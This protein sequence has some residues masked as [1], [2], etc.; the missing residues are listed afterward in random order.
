MFIQVKLLNGFKKPLW[1]KVPA[2][3]TQQSLKETIIQVPLRNTIIPAVVLREQL[4]HPPVAFEIKEAKEIEPFPADYHYMPFVTQLSSYYVINPL[5]IIMRIKSF[6]THE[7]KHR[8]PKIKADTEHTVKKQVTL[9]SEQQNIVDYVNPRIENPVYAP[10]VIHGVTG[11]GKTEC[12]KEAIK[13]AIFQNKSVILLLPEVTLAVNFAQRLSQELPSNIPLFSFHSS[14]S[15]REKRELWSALLQKR[16]VLIV[17]V[18]LPILLPIANLGLIIVDEEH[19]VGYQEK[20]HPKINSKEAALIRAKICNIPIILGSA[21][22]SVQTLY[23]VTQRTWKFFEIT[24]RFAG[25]FPDVHVELL[26][27]GKE[28]KQ[29]WITQPLYNAI[30]DRLAKKEQILLFLNRRGFSFF[31]QCKPCGFIFSCNSCSVSLTLHDHNVL[32]C[33]YC[34]HNQPMP[35]ACPRCKAPEAEFLKK[36]LGTQQLV[37]IINKLFPQARVERADMDTTTNKKKWQQIMADFESGVIDILVGTQTITKGYDFPRVTLV[38]IIWAD[39][40]LHFPSYNAAET[41]LQQLIQV[42]GRA[43]RHT[44]KSLVIVQAMEQHTIFDYINEKNYPLFYTFEQEVRK[45]VGYPPFVRFAHIT[46]KHT[47]EATIEKE[48]QHIASF[49]LADAH[50]NKTDLRVLGPAKPA[51][52]KIKNAYTRTII[53]KS[54]SIKT[55]I[56]AFKSVPSTIESQLFFDPNPLS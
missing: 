2:S 1:Y 43:G 46:L 24:Q 25:N 37:T 11:T 20:K 39:L 28:R 15:P 27:S 16:P 51:V 42:A 4:N 7:E 53:L 34:G 6:I 10:I 44:Q 40:N 36:G 5:H 38:G 21:T 33:H 3:W 8:E 29:F 55:I 35:T 19:E 32:N 9:T 23:N 26:T 14:V 41:T 17:G 18:H 47:T 54:S 56:D 30:K 22:P 52:H 49:L 12:Y 50:K 45:E 48:A 31:V 13:K